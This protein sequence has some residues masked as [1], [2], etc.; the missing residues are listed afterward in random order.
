MKKFLAIVLVLSIFT[1]FIG[2]KHSSN[3]SKPSLDDGLTVDY[4][5]NTSRSIT[6][7]PSNGITGGGVLVYVR[8]P[9]TPDGAGDTIP[10]EI[11]DNKAH[12]DTVP[13]NEYYV[14]LDFYIS[15]GEK[16]IFGSE[17]F[18]S[19]VATDSDNIE[20]Y[21]LP[22]EL[23]AGLSANGVELD[24]YAEAF[25]P[26]PEQTPEFMESTRITKFESLGGSSKVAEF[27]FE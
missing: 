9:D 27:N 7:S 18:T 13:G 20:F 1:I 12:F 24:I 2:C 23:K 5:S 11:I 6:I 26:T 3:N 25:D 16:I 4:K 14:F 15:V 8:G 22:D 10:V 21:I 17:I 19:F